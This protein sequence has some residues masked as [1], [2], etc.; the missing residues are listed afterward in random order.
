MGQVAARWYL[1]PRGFIVFWTMWDSLEDAQG[2]YDIDMNTV[3]SFPVTK[4][5]EGG[6]FA[7]DERAHVESQICRH[8]LH[9]RAVTTNQADRS[10]LC[11]FTHIS[12]DVVDAAGRRFPFAMLYSEGSEDEA[13]G[14]YAVVRHRDTHDV[15]ATCCGDGNVGHTFIQWHDASL[16]HMYVPHEGG[17]FLPTMSR[18]CIVR[19]K[20]MDCHRGWSLLMEYLNSTDSRRGLYFS[21]T[22]H[23]LERL[24]PVAAK[25][26]HPSKWCLFP[27]P[28]PRSLVVDV[29]AMYVKGLDVWTPGRE[30]VPMVVWQVIASF[31]G[32]LVFWDHTCRALDQL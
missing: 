22:R 15:V 27:Q 8:I 10:F 6:V 7:H 17:G 11:V 20:S 2:V 24:V 28:V 21:H 5:R 9:L 23:E 32:E 16:T 29:A 14:F 26:A 31:I 25:L 13:T 30:N 18:N 3:E 1:V 19:T 12:Y 4:M